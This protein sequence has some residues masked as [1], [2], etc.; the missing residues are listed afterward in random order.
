LYA[1]KKYYIGIIFTYIFI[2]LSGVD[3]SVGICCSFCG[4][5]IKKS[6]EFTGTNSIPSTNPSPN[7]NQIY[8]PPQTLDGLNGG[9]GVSGVFHNNNYFAYL[10]NLLTQINAK[11]IQYNK[12]EQNDLNIFFNCLD[13]IN[14]ITTQNIGLINGE[15]LTIYQN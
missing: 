4:D 11:I 9:V 7:T 12:I 3:V 15:F 6:I 5:F 10:T 1:K 13:Q 2:F 14:N 8:L